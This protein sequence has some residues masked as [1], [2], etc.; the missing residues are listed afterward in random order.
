MAMLM[1]FIGL[2]MAFT[3]FIALMLQV[4]Y[5]NGFDKHYAT[6]GRIY[7]VDKSGIDRSDVFRN[8]LPRGYVDDILTSS[9]HIAAGTISC[10]YIGEVVF[11][12][13]DKYGRH[14]FSYECD[15]VYP[16]IFDVFG[17][18]F[19]EGT[20]E[21]LDDL[22]KVAIPRSLAEKLY[23][24]ESAIGKVISHNEKYKFGTFRNSELVIGAVYEDLPANSQFDNDIYMNIG[25]I[26]EG[27]YGGAN[28]ICWILLDTPDNK[29]VVENN[30][31]DNYD[32]GEGTWLTDIELTP[33]EEIYFN[34]GENPRYKTGN[35][36]Q[37]WLMICISVIIM[38][39]GGI[40]YTTFFTSLAPMRIR[41]INTQKVLG[42]P[43]GKL[44]LSLLTESVIFSLAALMIAFAIIVP[45]TEWLAT[46]SLISTEFSFALNW[47]LTALAAAVSLA[48]GIIAGLYPSFY[49]TSVP[50]AFALKGDFGFSAGGR[51]FRTAMLILQYT[52]SFVLLI[53]VMFI[54][55]QNR[56][57]MEY[58]CGFDKDNI[59]VVEIS[60]NHTLDKGDWLRERLSALPEVIDVA[61]SMELMGCSDNYAVQTVSLNGE[62]IKVF[63]FYCSANFL[64]VMG[65]PVVDGRDFETSDIGK[66]IMNTRMK[67]LGGSIGVNRT[68]GEIIGQTAPVRMNSLR[69]AEAPACYILLPKEYGALTWT[70][71]RLHDGCDKSAAVSKINEVLSE[72]DPDY[73]FDVHFYDKVTDQLYADEK[74][75]SV[76]ISIFSLLASLLS[77]IGIFGQVLLDVQ[78]RK[79]DIAI[80]KVYGAESDVLLKEG[81]LKYLAI[82][83]VSFAVASP[84][85][86][87]SA[88]RWL[89]GFVERLPVT[90]FPFAVSLAIILPLTLAIV[91]L[92]YLRAANADPSKTLKTE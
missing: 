50:P 80:K 81:L 71:I 46:N 23:G 18:R 17:V 68:T 39:I 88:E 37:M 8:I 42:S 4:E 33:I 64:D 48:V 62:D 36:R 91:A 27:S 83:L 85:A 29:G 20:A 45:V 16:D 63:T 76:I 5:Q 12:T 73:I 78:Y 40:N 60:Q 28:Y 74:H 82:V 72:M 53:F 2:A 1:N 38:L 51:R 19:V 66:A 14:S 31:N 7:R 55:R 49:V 59:A 34:D 47:R 54:N 22:Q 69:N 58:E 10:P 41:S 77:L 30:F 25:S 75:K 21:A 35:R 15:V 89:Q 61:Y 3:A 32:Y 84:I 24:N 90:I 56:F 26:N 87:Y 43:I 9:S 6:A 65:I 13:S 52:I 11:T 67:N 79:R 57:M 44:R 70:Y 86:W 92:Q